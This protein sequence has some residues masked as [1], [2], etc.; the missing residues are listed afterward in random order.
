VYRATYVFEGRSV[1]VQESG[2]LE[3]FPKKNTY[4]DLDG[5]K[6]FIKSFSLIGKTIIY[7]LEK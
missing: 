5:K 7:V 4:I 6:F 3:D 1:S 2:D